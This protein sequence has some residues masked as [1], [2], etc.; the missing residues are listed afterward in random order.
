MALRTR[1]V[2]YG[3][4][5]NEFADDDE[6]VLQGVEGRCELELFIPDIEMSEL[7]VRLSDF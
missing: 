5:K 1:K 7:D 2:P 4:L 3:R 6:T